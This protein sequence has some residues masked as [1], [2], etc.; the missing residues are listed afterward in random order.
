MP[1]YDMAWILAFRVNIKI[2]KINKND[3]TKVNYKIL[4]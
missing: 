2:Q 4:S 3:T 1:K